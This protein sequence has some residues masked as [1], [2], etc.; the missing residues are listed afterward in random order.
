MNTFSVTFLPIESSTNRS[1]HLSR[2][3][4]INLHIS[5]HI[6]NDVWLHMLLGVVFLVLKTAVA[7]VWCY[8]QVALVT[9]C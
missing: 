4:F 7:Y 6:Y 5:S 9:S 3:N 2:N 1:E 8:I